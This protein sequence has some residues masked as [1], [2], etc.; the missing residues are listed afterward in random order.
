[1]VMH[2][3]LSAPSSRTSLSAPLSTTGST[4]RPMTP[5]TRPSPRRRW[6]ATW[7]ADARAGRARHGRQ[8]LPLA[9]AALSLARLKAASCSTRACGRASWRCVATLPA[10]AGAQSGRKPHRCSLDRPEG[11]DDRF[12]CS[13]DAR[14]TLQRFRPRSDPPAPVPPHDGPPLARR[15]GSGDGSPRSRV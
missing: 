15:R 13:S 7:P 8:A 2:C 12:G 9:P 11:N 1:L 4:A 6:S 14:T 10:G 5:T 3:A